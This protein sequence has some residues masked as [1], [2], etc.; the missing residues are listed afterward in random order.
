M[1]RTRQAASHG[2]SPVDILKTTA[3]LILTVGGIFFAVLFGGITY[4][5]F[6][7]E[8]VGA[9]KSNESIL[10]K[11]S[12]VLYF[13][14][15]F[16]GVRLDLAREA[17]IY[18][19]P[20][21]DVQIDP[22]SASLAFVIFVIFG[23]MYF[24]ED[25]NTAGNDSLLSQIGSLILID[26]NTKQ[27]VISWIT[28]NGSFVIL[29]GFNFLWFFNIFLWRWF[30]EYFIKPLARKSR[31]HYKREDDYFGIVK[32]D[33]L[34]DYLDGKWQWTRYKLGTAYL[35][36]LDLIIVPIQHGWLA[37]TTIA[38]VFAVF[39]II[40]ESWVWMERLRAGFSITNIDK[41]SDAY[42]LRPNVV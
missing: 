1:P 29:S 3:T 40:F 34:N 5:A 6:V 21:P 35:L 36:C 31:E 17:N 23:V 33:I 16:A 14:S 42:G 12:I 19:L 11:S 8:L 32:V 30:V 28:R 27:Q 37:R 24:I 38:A 2:P 9:L 26:R 41:L 15:W 25:I 20:G 22:K 13:T 10:W 7:H 18:R 4:S 39:V